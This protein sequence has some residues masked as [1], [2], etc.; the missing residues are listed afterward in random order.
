M[1]HG[2]V[3]GPGE[4]KVGGISGVRRVYL[5]AWPALFGSS[6]ASVVV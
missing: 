3:D 2:T 6:Q 1:M 4:P 5:S